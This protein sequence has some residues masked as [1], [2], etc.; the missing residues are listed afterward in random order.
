ML[1]REMPVD[2]AARRVGE[3]DT[4][5][6]RVL[7]HYVGEAR[8]QANFSEVRQVAVD[9]VRR[10][11]QK[12][13]PELK[14]TRYLWLKTPENLTAKQRIR[15][16]EIR[17]SRSHLKTALAYRIKRSFKKFWTRPASLAEALV[18]R[19]Y[20][21]ATHSQPDPVIRVAKTIKEHWRG[22]LRWHTTRVTNG[23]PEGLNSL[24]QAVKAKARGYRS[25]RNL[26]V[27]TYLIGGT[28][29]LSLPEL[30]H[31]K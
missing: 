30:T 31:T 3:T 7:H 29:E 28:L 10:Q 12:G 24:I 22:V 19:W 16:E 5:L 6:W 21:R 11:E 25:T 8:E 2:A 13:R 18:K 9:E 20:Y 27:L 1:C 14:K 15:L 17:P 23:V 4:R 26:I